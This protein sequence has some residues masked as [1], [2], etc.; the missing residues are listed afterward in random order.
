MT[1]Y[2]TKEA[3]RDVEVLKVW[4][5]WEAV[6]SAGLKEQQEQT[7]LGQCGTKSPSELQCHTGKSEERNAPA[8]FFCLPISIYCLQLAELNQKGEGKRI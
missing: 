1:K 4:P 5:E 6:T 8:S 3:I 2:S 7:G